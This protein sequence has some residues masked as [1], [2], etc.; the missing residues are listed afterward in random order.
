MSRFLLLVLLLLPLTG[1]TQNVYRTTD[2]QGNVVF[3]DS[4]PVQCHTSGSS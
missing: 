1:L 2:A 3:T 4:T